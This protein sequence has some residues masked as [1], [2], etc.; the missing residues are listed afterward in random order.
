MFH[1]CD[2]WCK[3]WPHSALSVIATS[4]C[5]LSWLVLTICLEDLF[6]L[7]R[8]HWIWPDRYR[9]IWEVHACKSNVTFS[10]IIL[11]KYG[12][13]ECPSNGLGFSHNKEYNFFDICKIVN[14]PK[15]IICSCSLFCSF[16]APC[17]P[18]D[19]PVDGFV[20]GDNHQH[21]GSVQ[22]WCKQ[23]FTLRGSANSQ[24]V[25]GK[26]DS[27]SPFCEGALLIVSV[28]YYVPI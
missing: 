20:F 10:G 6:Y 8:Y 25:D 1:V 18:P 16:S 22:F 2:W 28:A 7:K 3:P 13:R 4:K 11:R 15:R 14:Y 9:N 24:C 12:W 26:W 17:S 21:H 27:P 23:G 19:V 5:K